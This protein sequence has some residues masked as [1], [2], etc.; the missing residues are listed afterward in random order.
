MKKSITLAVLL[1]ASLTLAG[2]KP[3]HGAPAPASADTD[4]SSTAT[5][6][7]FSAPKLSA[8]QHG[9]I[10]GVVHFTGP[11]PKRIDIDMSMDPACAFGASN[12]SEPYV[13]DKDRVANVYIY[14][15]SGV[16]PTLAVLSTR[17]VRLDQTGCRYAPHVIALQQGAA[18]EF[19][20]SDATMHNIHVTPTQSGNP[21]VDIS[22]APK[23]TAQMEEFHVAETMI[24]VRCNNH[25]WMSAFINVAPN[26]YFD[27]TDADG[28]FS[29]PRLPPGNYILA[30][31]HEKMGEQDIPVTVTAG[32]TVTADFTFR[33][34]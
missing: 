13:I 8:Y 6:P 3:R 11:A 27:V 28:S 29:I 23:G 18:V 31:V 21:A 30:A 20:N 33:A 9:R 12:M 24:P 26:P 15:K 4:T 5:P 22:Q 7:I 34:K 14:I 19:T 32:G 16:S 2:C 10:A 17:P 25:P 1:S